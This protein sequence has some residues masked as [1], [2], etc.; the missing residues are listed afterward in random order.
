MKMETQKYTL[1]EL[2]NKTRDEIR[3]IASKF[4]VKIFKKQ[5]KQIL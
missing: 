5:L 2:Q 4:S 1:I 3:K